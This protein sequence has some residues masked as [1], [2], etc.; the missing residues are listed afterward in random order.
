MDA[1]SPTPVSEAVVPTVATPAQIIAGEVAAGRLKSS[2]G[3]VV[4]DL[5][6]TEVTWGSANYRCRKGEV[7]GHQIEFRLPTLKELRALQTAG[8]LVARGDYWSMIQVKEGDGPAQAAKV[9][10]FPSGR[11]LDRDKAGRARVQCVW[12]EN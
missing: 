5:G 8:L 12:R 2:D 1:A 10:N 3:L 7:A 9:H 6:K 4:G 11:H